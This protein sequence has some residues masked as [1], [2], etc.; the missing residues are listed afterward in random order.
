[1]LL[2]SLLFVTIDS[3]NSPAKDPDNNLA[4]K[5]QNSLLFD[6]SKME[7]TTLVHESNLASI[8]SFTYLD[9]QNVHLM[10]KSGTSFTVEK[11]GTEKVGGF[12]CT[13]FII[14]TYLNGKPRTGQPKKNLWFTSD[15]GNSNVWFI[16]PYLYCLKD[17]YEQ[18]KLA[19]AGASG[20]V[21]KWEIGPSSATLTDHQQNSVPSSVFDIPSG[22][23]K[24]DLTSLKAP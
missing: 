10:E 5:D 24:R 7:K 14:T 6:F 4:E 1:M 22:Y 13:H 19:D 8:M 23:T 16:G 17:N 9:Q 12:N 20:I 15:L 3:K 18:K 11:V 2:F 21:V